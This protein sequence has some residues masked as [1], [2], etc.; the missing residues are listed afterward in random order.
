MKKLIIFIVLVVVVGGALYLFKGGTPSDT[1]PTASPTPTPSSS[2]SVSPSVMASPT[3]TPVASPKKTEVSSVKTFT[4]TGKS[5]SF[6]PSEIT[7]NKGDTVKIIFKNTGGNHNWVI[8]EFNAQTKTI[9]GGLTDTIQFVA[10]KTGT[11]QYY[12]SVGAHRQLGMVGN[13]IVK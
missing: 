8:D 10:D 9:I 11:F 12:C 2:P 7:V 3:P 1:N 4:V 13:L 6:V 5:Y